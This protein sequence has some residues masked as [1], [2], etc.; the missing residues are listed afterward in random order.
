MTKVLSKEQIKLLPLV[1]RFRKD[2][3]LVGGTAIALQLRHRRSIDF[4]LFID[5]PLQVDKIKRVIRERNQIDKLYVENE[6]ELTMMVDEVKMTFYN[7]PFKLKETVNYKKIISMPSL[8]V[9]GAMKAYTLGRRA[10][11]KDYIDLYF[12]FKNLSFKRVVDKSNQIFKGEFNE[13]LFREQLCYFKD[14]KK[15]EKLIYLPG[16]EVSDTKIE[17]ELKKQS[18]SL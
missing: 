15:E 9:L 12:I 3:I 10:K 11:W 5:Q 7:Y 13:K 14:L 17:A 8:V 16:F 18:L 2:F 6:N 1:N 4:D